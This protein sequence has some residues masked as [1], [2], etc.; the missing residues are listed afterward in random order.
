MVSGDTGEVTRPLGVLLQGRVSQHE[1]EL[2]C[3]TPRLVAA[4]GGVSLLLGPQPSH[5]LCA[6]SDA[7]Q[8]PLSSSGT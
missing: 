7:L 3:P 2:C 8:P 1:A 5:A 4:L 6:L